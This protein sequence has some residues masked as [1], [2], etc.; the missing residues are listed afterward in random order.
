MSRRSTIAAIPLTPIATS[1]SPWRQGRPNVSETMTATSTPNRARS[2][3][4]T[5][6]ADRSESTG[7]SAAQ[8]S[9]DVREVDA[10][11]RAH[12]AVPRLADHEVA[13]RA[14]DAHRLRL[15]E[16]AARVAVERVE[17]ARAGPS[18]FDT[19]FCVTTRQSPS[20]SGV[21]CAAAASAISSASSSPGR[22]SPMPVDRD[23]GERG[24]HR[25]SIRR[26]RR[27]CGGRARSR[28]PGCAS[29]CR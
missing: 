23:D 29:S 16:P 9:L 12:E 6:L 2:A 19:I 3:S 28:S 27:G 22:I 11:V 17:L 4:R 8:P 10:R 20:A 25:S 26:P 15:H 5:C 21:S 7:S 24:G 18:A 13:A 1:V 14:H